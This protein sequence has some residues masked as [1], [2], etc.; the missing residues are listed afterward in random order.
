[1]PY[2]VTDLEAV[3][4]EPKRPA[5]FDAFWDGV[6]SELASVPLEWDRT[7]FPQLSAP[8]HRIDVIRFTSLNDRLVYGW[9]AVPDDMPTDG[10][11]NG[12]LWL[13]GYSL[14]NLK[15]AAESLYPNTVTFGLNLHGNLPDTPYVHPSKTGDD[16]VTQ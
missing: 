16:Y 2:S 15:P 6:Q 9:Y 13:P 12:Y 7:P 8:G 3:H 4:S 1:M 11:G 5:D 10:C 14:G